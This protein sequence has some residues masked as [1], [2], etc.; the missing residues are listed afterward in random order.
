MQTSNLE[1]NISPDIQDYRFLTRRPKE[2]AQP[3][4]WDCDILL[5]RLR[6]C[7]ERAQRGGTSGFRSGDY[8]GTGRGAE[9]L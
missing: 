1:E 5:V 6:Q 2:W 7:T 8:A 3:L 4:H 9:W